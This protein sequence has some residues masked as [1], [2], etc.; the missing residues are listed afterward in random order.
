MTALRDEAVS[1]YR[2]RIQSGRR[3]KMTSDERQILIDW[4]KNVSNH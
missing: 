3:T 1:N 2:D 4:F